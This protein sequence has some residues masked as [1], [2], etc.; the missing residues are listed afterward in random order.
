MPASQQ[1]KKKKRKKQ[2]APR[3]SPPPPTPFF[4]PATSLSH[5]FSLTHSI[6]HSFSFPLPRL[7]LHN[8]IFSAR[9]QIP[10]GKDP[11]PRLT[12]AAVRRE[13]QQARA[14]EAHATWRQNGA[15]RARRIWRFLA[16]GKSW[17]DGGR[18]ERA[19]PRRGGKAKTHDPPLYCRRKKNFMAVL[20][21]DS[22]RPQHTRPA[23]AVAKP[24]QETN[25]G[26][27]RSYRHRQRPPRCR[28]RH[29]RQPRSCTLLWPMMLQAK[30]ADPRREQQ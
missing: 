25:C 18:R 3:A 8:K 26:G 16:N 21:L 13:L 24:Q 1:G 10:G 19:A 12:C 14:A 23:V 15:W 22:T 11:P 7:R 29:Q 27:G 6:N 4:L 20:P 30:S 5:T 28:L 2:Q 9:S 17:Q